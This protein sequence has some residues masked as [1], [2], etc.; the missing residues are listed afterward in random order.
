MRL[1]IVFTVVRL[2]AAGSR[3]LAPAAVDL[4]VERNGFGDLAVRRVDTLE[5]WD[6]AL[7]AE[8]R[9]RVLAQLALVER[10][11]RDREIA[12]A[13]AEARLRAAGGLPS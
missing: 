7:R 5:G 13:L 9:A 4:I 8:E 3:L 2:A 11:E 1:A 10:I 6:G 12:A